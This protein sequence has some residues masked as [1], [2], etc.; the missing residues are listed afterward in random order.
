M[1]ASNSIVLNHQQQAIVDYVRKLNDDCDKEL[2]RLIFLSGSAGTGKSCVVREMMKLENITVVAKTAIAAHNIGGFTINKEFGMDFSGKIKRITNRHKNIKLLII[3][4]IS[5]VKGIEFCS[6]DAYFR[7]VKNNNKPFGGIIVVV[8][9]DFGQLEPIFDEVDDYI[10]DTPIWKKFKEFNLFINMRQN[11]E[12]F[13]NHLLTIREGK[14]VDFNYWNDFVQTTAQPIPDDTLYIMATNKEVNSYNLN[15]ITKLIKN[16]PE[17]PIATLK[18]SI[19][20]MPYYKKNDK[21]IIYP[22]GTEDRLSNDLLI[23]K[24]ARIIITFNNAMCMHRQHNGKLC[25]VSS[26]P[27]YDGGHVGLID[28]EDGVEFYVLPMILK[29]YTKNKHQINI[30]VGYP[31]AHAWA[32]TIHKIQGITANN[33]ALHAE[34]IFAKGQ[35]YVALSRVRNSKGLHLLSRI[36]PLFVIPAK[37]DVG[38]DELTTIMQKDDN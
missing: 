27:L 35:L 13:I 22:F 19:K 20:E 15:Q 23:T 1:S 18:R 10:Y 31:F 2:E 12:T 30:Y 8:V 33:L 24:G 5:M 16:N 28:D 34:H 21:E 37:T 38:L 11:E 9:G 26:V 4:E 36:K 25:T 32:V 29:V 3:D 7:A 14:N 17:Q 6:I